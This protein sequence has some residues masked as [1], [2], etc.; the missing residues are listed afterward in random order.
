[1]ICAGVCNGA[2]SQAPSLSAYQADLE[3]ALFHRH[4]GAH[5]KDEIARAENILPI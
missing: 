1:M 2:K 4:H 5:D 3:C